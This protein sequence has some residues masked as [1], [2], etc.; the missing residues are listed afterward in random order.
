MRLHGLGCNAVLAPAIAAA[1][2]C[3]GDIVQLCQ[4]LGGRSVETHCHTIC[5]RAGEALPE[6]LV[7]E[8]VS[9]RNVT[10]HAGSLGMFNCIAC[11]TTSRSALCFF[12]LLCLMA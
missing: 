2:T 4:H 6:A 10:L 11:S 12:V 1:V 9:P 8:H 5:D 7:L 3:A